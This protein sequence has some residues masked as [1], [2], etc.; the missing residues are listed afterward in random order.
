VLTI[1]EARL[2]PKN[3]TVRVR[4]VVTVPSDLIEP[5]SAVIQDASD[6]I[7]IRLSGDA[8]SLQR[9]ELVDLVGAMSTKSGMLTIRVTLPPQRLGTAPDPAAARRTTGQLG[10]ELE[11]QLVVTRGALTENPR[12]SS[13]GSVSFAIDD[14]SGEMR[15]FISPRAGVDV[16]GVHRGDW[17]EVRGVLAQDTTGSQPDRGYRIWPRAVSDLEILAAAVPTG[18]T[19]AGGAASSR[20]GS[21]GV[22]QG[23]KLSNGSQVAAAHDSRPPG[24]AQAATANLPMPALKSVASSDPAGSGGLVATTAASTRTAVGGDGAPLRALGLLVVSLA[25]LL[26]IGVLAWRSGAVG[27]AIALVNAMLTAPTAPAPATADP[28]PIAQ[29]TVI[30]GPSEHAG[31]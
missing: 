28:E 11:A 24:L 20:A 12:R 26:A 13:A 27:R 21:S 1:G 4:G 29:L 30:R 7:L 25:A 10:E 5:G 18:G 31:G 17:I 15:I 19:S 2:R 6:A 3:A 14:G 23:T 8:G 9:G 22:G 16:S